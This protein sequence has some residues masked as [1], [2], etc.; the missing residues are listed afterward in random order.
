MRPRAGQEGR[1]RGSRCAGPSLPGAHCPALALRGLQ[2]QPGGR[3]TCAR[4]PAPFLLS[5]GSVAPP[6][7]AALGRGRGGCSPKGFRG[8]PVLGTPPSRPGPRQLPWAA[9]G[10]ASLSG[11]HGP[12]GRGRSLCARRRLWGLGLGSWARAPEGCVSARAHPSSGTSARAPGR[13]PPLLRPQVL[14]RVQG[15]FG[16]AAGVSPGM[17]GRGGSWP[18]AEA[19]TL[20]RV[21]RVV[22]AQRPTPARSTRPP[23]GWGPRPPSTPS[24]PASEAAGKAS[25]GLCLFLEFSLAG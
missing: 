24:G 22:T 10:P 7:V 5:S 6:R 8:N 21:G 23:A 4:A 12:G 25:S 19:A 11:A 14:V 13:L 9:P 18:Q 1:G 2:T 3:G 15:H 20:G 16:W 17:A